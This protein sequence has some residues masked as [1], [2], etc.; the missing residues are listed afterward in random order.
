MGTSD[1]TKRT[2]EIGT[3]VPMLNALE[4]DLTATT[5]TTDALLTQRTLAQYLHRQG[6]V[7]HAAYMSTF[8]T[9]PFMSGQPW[10]FLI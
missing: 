10:V 1:E 5:V 8:R 2:N 4:L 6:G 7:V 3:V 9:L